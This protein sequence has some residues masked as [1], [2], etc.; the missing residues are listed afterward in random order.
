MSSICFSAKAQESASNALNGNLED[1]FEYV[2]KK[3]SKYENYKVISI[4]NFNYLRKSAL[5]SI[6]FYKQEIATSKAKIED[7][8][9]QV[10]NLNAELQ[11]A[12]AEINQL[13]ESLKTTSFLGITL[14]KGLF[15]MIVF[16]VV[17]GL[18]LLLVLFIMKFRSAKTDSN[19]AIGNLS[20]VEDEYTEYKRKAMEK[21][22]QLGRRLQDEINKN[23]KDKQ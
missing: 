21:E 17:S 3:S 23:K 2:F 11:S 18:L 5:D 10:D 13:N 14:N 22:Q 16:G 19:V 15:N 8:T 7:I 1:R 12:R 6:N 9:A 4:S 20:R